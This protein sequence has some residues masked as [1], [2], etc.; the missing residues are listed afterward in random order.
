MEAAPP[1][2]LHVCGDPGHWD[3][4]CPDGPTPHLARRARSPLATAPAPATAIQ[5]A[6]LEAMFGNLVLNNG[7]AEG[8]EAVEE[9]EEAVDDEEEEA[10]EEQE[11]EAAAEEQ[12]EQEEAADE[13]ALS[14]GEEDTSDAA[15]A[16]SFVVI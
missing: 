6:F 15:S 4:Q 16:D 11:E 13:E 5:D 12:E 7:A 14:E 8:E 3:V 1:E 10:A 9:E 2:P